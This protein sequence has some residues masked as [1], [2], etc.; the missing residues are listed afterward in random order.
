MFLPKPAGERIEPPF[1]KNLPKGTGKLDRKFR[2]SSG[3]VFNQRSPAEEDYESV[4]FGLHMKA[5]DF[6]LGRSS[7]HSFKRPSSKSERLDPLFSRMSQEDVVKQFE[8]ELNVVTT[9]IEAQA[10]M[11]ERERKI[12]TEP[13][14]YLLGKACEMKSESGS[15]KVGDGEECEVNEK[16]GSQL[17]SQDLL[18]R[19]QFESGHL[20][21][22][23]NNETRKLQNKKRLYISQFWQCWL[24]YSDFLPKEYLN[25]HMLKT[26]EHL[27]GVFDFHKL[28]DNMFVEALVCLYKP[29]VYDRHALFLDQCMV[30]TNKEMEKMPDFIKQWLDNNTMNESA[31]ST[32]IPINRTHWQFDD[33]IKNV[34][35]CRALFG[36]A[37]CHYLIVLHSNPLLNI[38]RAV[39]QLLGIIDFLENLVN[40]AAYGR[41]MKKLIESDL[42]TLRCLTQ[43]VL[44]GTYYIRTIINSLCDTGHWNK[45]Q[46]HLKFIIKHLKELNN[47]DTTSIL[48]V[49]D[50]YLALYKCFSTLG[51]YENTAAILSEAMIFLDNIKREQK[52]K[53]REEVAVTDSLEHG[54]NILLFGVEVAILNSGKQISPPKDIVTP[55][56]LREEA[57]TTTKAIDSEKAVQPLGQSSTAEE[58]GVQWIILNGEW[59]KVGSGDSQ[60]EPVADIHQLNN[61]SDHSKDTNTL[62]DHNAEVYTPELLKHREDYNT[63]ESLLRNTKSDQMNF[64]PLYFFSVASHFKP[65]EDQ[66]L[67]TLQSWDEPLNKSYWNPDLPQSLS[68][69]TSRTVSNLQSRQ[70][71]N[72]FDIPPSILALVRQNSPTE[73]ISEIAKNSARSSMTVNNRVANLDVT[74][75]L[76][77]RD[78]VVP[79]QMKHMDI[80]PR[81]QTISYVGLQK[82]QRKRPKEQVEESAETKQ[83]RSSSLLVINLLQVFS[84]L[85]DQFKAACQAIHVTLEKYPTNFIITPDKYDRFGSQYFG[86]YRLLD[87]QFQ[88]LCC[89]LGG[90]Y[91]PEQF[92]VKHD[93]KATVS[94]DEY[95]RLRNVGEVDIFDFFTFM[96][97][98]F[99]FHEWLKFKKL[100]GFIDHFLHEHEELKSIFQEN[101]EEVSL[102]E[103]MIKFSTI[104]RSERQV[105]FQDEH[106]AK[107]EVF[108]NSSNVYRSLLSLLCAFKTWI[109]R[110]IFNER[111]SISLPLIN[112]LQHLWSVPKYLIEN[113]FEKRLNRRSFEVTYLINLPLQVLHELLNVFPLIDPISSLEICKLIYRA[114]DSN[115]CHKENTAVVQQSMRQ[116]NH[117]LSLIGLYFSY[118]PAQ[119]YTDHILV[120]AIPNI[121]QLDLPTVTDRHKYQIIMHSTQY[122]GNSLPKHRFWVQISRELLTAYMILLKLLSVARI[123]AFEFKNRHIQTLVKDGFRKLTHKKLPP[124]FASNL[125]DIQKIV[126]L[127]GNNIHERA[128]LNIACALNSQTVS[129]LQRKDLLENTI[130]LLQSNAGSETYQPQKVQA[131]DE[132]CCS[133]PEIL[134]KSSTSI[135]LRAYPPKDVDG[136]YVNYVAMYQFFGKPVNKDSIVTFNDCHLQ[137]T[138]ETVC[139]SKLSNENEIV[140]VGEYTISHLCENQAYVFAAAA[141][142]SS[143]QLIGSSIGKSTKPIVAC[144]SLNRY[145]I[146]EDLSLAAY[147]LNE[148]SIGEYSKSFLISNLFDHSITSSEQAHKLLSSVA[149]ISEYLSIDRVVVHSKSIL[150]R[151]SSMLAKKLV[152]ILFYSVSTAISTILKCRGREALNSQSIVVHTDSMGVVNPLKSQKL[153]AQLLCIIIAAIETAD[154]IA[155]SNLV[156]HGILKCFEILHKLIH[157]SSKSS[158]LILGYSVCHSKFMKNFKPQNFQSS[159][160]IREIFIPLSLD[161]CYCYASLHDLHSLQLTVEST[162]HFIN[163]TSHGKD[164]HILNSSM[165]EYLWFG[166]GLKQR[167]I[168]YGTMQHYVPD[169]LHHS[170]LATSVNFMQGICDTQETIGQQQEELDFYFEWA[171]SYESFKSREDAIPTKFDSQITLRELYSALRRSNPEIVF[172]DLGKFKRNPRFVELVCRVIEWTFKNQYFNT[173]ILFS[174]NIIEWIGRRNQAFVTGNFTHI[175]DVDLNV[176]H[177]KKRSL[178][179][180]KKSGLV[181]F[182]QF[183]KKSRPKSQLP[184]STFARP[185]KHDSFSEVKKETNNSGEL[186]NENE[187]LKST[188]LLECDQNSVTHVEHQDNTD[189]TTLLE[190]ETPRMDLSAQNNKE[191]TNKNSEVNDQKI[192]REVTD[193]IDNAGTK[194]PTI[195]SGQTFSPKKKMNYKMLLSALG[196]HD[197]ETIIK[198][199][200]ILELRWHNLWKRQRYMQ[201]MRALLLHGSFWNSELLVMHGDL[202]FY[203]YCTV[204]LGRQ[205]ILSG[206]PSNEKEQL[207]DMERFTSLNLGCIKSEYMNLS[208]SFTYFQTSYSDQ[209]LPGNILNAVHRKSVS[210]MQIEHSKLLVD[211]FQSYVQGA[212]LAGRAQQ[213]I[214]VMKASEKLI[215]AKTFLEEYNI[216]EP[217]RLLTHMWRA[218]YIVSEYIIEFLQVEGVRFTDPLDHPWYTG[219]NFYLTNTNFKPTAPLP[220]LPLCCSNI[221]TYEFNFKNIFEA[222]SKVAVATWAD[223]ASGDHRH[224]LVYFSR[225]I[226]F[227]STTAELLVS[228]KQFHRALKFIEQVNSIFGQALSE[229]LK[230]LKLFAQECIDL[231]NSGKVRSN[232]TIVPAN[233]WI[234]IAQTMLPSSDANVSHGPEASRALYSQVIM[235]I[236][237]AQNAHGANVGQLLQNELKQ[238]LELNTKF[239]QTPST[240]LCYSVD[241]V[242]HMLDMQGDTL[243]LSGH[244]DAASLCW[245]KSIQVSKANHL[246]LDFI[247]MNNK[248]VSKLY[249]PV[250]VDADVSVVSSYIAA[251]SSSKLM[252]YCLN[253]DNAACTKWLAFSTQMYLL[254]L[255][256]TVHANIELQSLDHRL[257]FLMP[258]LLLFSDP[259]KVNPES[260]IAN[261]LY[262]LQERGAG[263]FSTTDNQ[264]KLMLLSIV[265]YIAESVLRSNTLLGKALIAKLEVLIKTGNF[266]SAYEGLFKLA[267][268]K[269]VIPEVMVVCNVELPESVILASVQGN[270][271]VLKH[272][273]CWWGIP[274]EQLYRLL[275]RLGELTVSQQA[276]AVYSQ[277][278]E[279]EFRKV[280]CLFFTYLISYPD[281]EWTVLNSNDTVLKLIKEMDHR[282]VPSFVLKAIFSIHGD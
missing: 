80:T 67:N 34:N 154:I 127:S 75:N 99:Q 130:L 91:M 28:A 188:I 238:L 254:P 282:E 263:E 70:Y 250:A 244:L 209:V 180:D 129:K 30:S 148:L 173:S 163:K 135:T 109:T 118:N 104:M 150:I 241:V 153:N 217:G 179:I 41:S 193:N 3:D 273:T 35:I 22:N 45:A 18:R 149:S 86:T 206:Q 210:P 146:W 216:P 108:R 201:R 233:Q 204:I 144:S 221:R 82:N 200:Q 49:I 112:F 19:S 44:N 125:N 265:I 59:T 212:V 230:P 66:L 136:K 62:Q 105:S 10:S 60:I 29:E 6:G 78:S 43:T 223:F 36:R 190:S 276:S 77:E 249:E 253:E 160:L 166:S 9:K 113:G 58:S 89:Q 183:I 48:W 20:P 63:R 243:C 197:H 218:F 264:D 280:Q 225:I 176:I 27:I 132:L 157:A 279:E 236:A 123:K 211:A 73:Q 177:T 74:E 195:Q 115:N 131:T 229:I 88:M 267:G 124:D 8:E 54:L 277:Q 278:F 215:H 262:L 72:T 220:A 16:E 53:N 191:E 42:D 133:S 119:T 172:Q 95:N 161:L 56:Q 102:Y 228:G 270:F 192:D 61:N 189:K 97:Y 260:T 169:Y 96:R 271:P 84:S 248:S 120:P 268:G 158:L 71:S 202:S 266:S 245:K 98:L 256:R 106:L 274:S 25:E 69:F 222:N 269:Y 141:Y 38:A 140:Y 68:G 165:L 76:P 138:A 227:L 1:Y 46:F 79:A 50:N 258:G 232:Q 40:E 24:K 164:L 137:G 126:R 203:S 240:L 117:C 156:I 255:K 114:N 101:I 26:A 219:T 207:V 90:K 242:A 196:K 32:K 152:K 23:G 194:Q 121:E 155:D 143:G 12:D 103:E 2:I 92:V 52:V 111:W 175:E 100:Y 142:N 7:P 198:A 51:D 83:K 170:I 205:K 81:K 39:D 47:F 199:I 226:R 272:Q 259:I 11:A 37:I 261:I 15:G 275:T 5:A 224:T 281:F 128:V 13:L 181:D 178:F 168:S 17:I 182:A 187:Y 237:A 252:Q 87:I 186:P 208:N 31:V 107:P 159:S 4:I 231:I 139:S 147:S 174:S 55:S 251:N 21:N 145:I 234:S 134:Q 213:W 93:N 184:I 214:N 239:F 94:T 185:Q 122:S 64:D 57:Q 235:R 110:Q 171:N 33:P 14:L 247:D 162:S 257:P 151:T 85:R 246:C 116:I 167:R 65:A